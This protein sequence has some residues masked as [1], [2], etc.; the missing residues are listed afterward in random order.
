MSDLR[1]R[2]RRAAFALLLIGTSAAVVAPLGAQQNAELEKQ[3]K[4]LDEI[5]QERERLQRQ[6]TQIE[7]QVS[8]VGSQLRNLERRKEATTELVNGI[9][10]EISTLGSQLERTSAELTLTQDNLA[11][12]RAVLRR[13]L[14]DIYKRGPLYTFQVLLAAE[15]FGDLLTRYKYL[16]LTSQ[17]D[18]NLV[19]DV[20]KLSSDVTRRRNDLLG[21][22]SELDRRREE[23]EAELNNFARLADERSTRLK[24][25]ERTSS[26]GKQRITTLERD[27]NRLND[28]L[29]AL[30]KARRAAEANRAARPSTVNAPSN[31]GSLTTADLG[32]LDWPVDGEIL[33][34][35]GRDSLKNGGVVRHNGIGIRAAVGTPVKVIESG[36]VV[37]AQRLSTYGLAVFIEHGDGYYS[38]YMQLQNSSVTVGQEVKRGQVIGTVGG[39]NSGEGPHLYFEIRG[40][41]QIAL[42]PTTWLRRRGGQ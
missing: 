23:R 1:R 26:Q 41:N 15:S 35:F 19:R 25:L 10:R 40:K 5:R 32:K 17:Q 39:E 37:L 34:D 33:Y 22:R 3:R 24:S 18:R 11:D 13:R 31:A 21:I 42:D 30:E 2:L 12:R 8:D 9:E 14:V 28:I 4:R 38:G 7:G 16:Y 36:K 27:E 6:Q 29:A 20:E